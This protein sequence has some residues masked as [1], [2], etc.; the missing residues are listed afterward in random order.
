MGPAKQGL[1]AIAAGRASGLALRAGGRQ[2]EL[3]AL[4]ETTEDVKSGYAVLYPGSGSALA[5][6]RAGVL[7]A[8]P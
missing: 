5:N 7:F 4:L 8:D 2:Q 3:K 1:E 6:L